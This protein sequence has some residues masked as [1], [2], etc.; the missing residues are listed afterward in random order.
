MQRREY[1]RAVDR[2]R[3][4]VARLPGWR[5]EEHDGT[6]A[7]VDA[8]HG[9]GVLLRLDSRWNAYLV[10]YFEAVDKD[11]LL[12]LVAL[13]EVVPPEGPAHRAAVAFLK[14]LRLADEPGASPRQVATGRPTASEPVE[15]SSPD[16]DCG[17]GGNSPPWSREVTHL[18]E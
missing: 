9:G 2:F 14:S 4:L 8:L 5:V 18:V 13:L 3:W 7:L 12:A 11:R 17:R 10:R 6:P 1:E 15:P 16:G